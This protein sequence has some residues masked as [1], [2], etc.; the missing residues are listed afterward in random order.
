MSEPVLKVE[1]LSIS[2]RTREGSVYATEQVSFDL[3]KG[4]V[5]A[6]VG[7][8]GS[9]KTTA[10]MAILR[11]L[12]PE[13]EVVSGHVRFDGDDLL[14]LDDRALRTIRG[15]RIATIFQDP[16]AGLNPVISVG[17]Q[18]AETL[19]SHLGI[20]KKEARQQAVGILAGV[21]LS[22]PERIARAFPFQLSGGMCQRVMIGMATALD[23]E[24]II[25]D[26]PTSALDVTIQAQILHQLDELRRKKGTS[27]LLI[28]HDFGVVAQVADE[29][30]VMYAGRMIETGSADQMLDG[31]LHPYTHALLATLPRLDNVGR[32]LTAIPGSPPDLSQPI[33]HCPFIPRCTKV[34]N[35]CR[36]EPAPALGMFEH[37][38]HP[39]ACY[40]PVW[41]T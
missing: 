2:Y 7:E 30:A 9:G 10:A 12:P 5:L 1:D 33:D 19:Q 11:L 18:V 28:T 35:V 37:A 3:R 27:I 20:K 34:M 39:V 15:R 40:N 21:G 38:T 14:A 13:A 26:E 29:V 32:S 25:A 24:V 41:Q 16:I 36:Q 22:D 23:P 31:P 17:D 6:L 4:E 8:S